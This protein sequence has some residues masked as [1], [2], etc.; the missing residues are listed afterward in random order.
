[1]AAPLPS[2]TKKKVLV[3]DDDPFHREMCISA[4]EEAGFE[5]V[6]AADGAEALDKFDEWDFDA[7]IVDLTMPLVDGFEVIRRLRSTSRTEHVP[8]ILI[9]GHDD[10]ESVEKAYELGA[11]SFLAKPVNWALFVHHVQ[12]I[13]RASQNAGE[14]RETT[15]AI[16]Y[17]SRL[18][19]NLMSVLANEFRGPLKQM[20][21]FSELLRLEVDGPLGSQI[22]HEYVADICK[23]VEQ[24][25]VLLLKMLHFGKALSREIALEETLF[26]LRAYLDECFAGSQESARRREV[27]IVVRHGISRDVLCHADKALLGQAIKSIIENAIKLSPRGQKVEIAADIDDAGQFVLSALDA[28]PVLTA[29]QIHSILRASGAGWSG[30]GANTERDVGL[31][32]SR[33]LVEAHGGQLVLQPVSGEGTRASLVLPAARLA[34]RQGSVAVEHQALKLAV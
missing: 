8:L 11:T 34:T 30:G 7:A 13:L 17:L 20:Y 26:S 12:F 10:A 14:L 25:N 23:S 28:G 27:E 9:T 31:T 15:H 32:V 22:Y 18:K 29:N 19:T 3:A 16:D 1:M 4:L 2:G 21:G 24:M 33:L 6:A 5:V